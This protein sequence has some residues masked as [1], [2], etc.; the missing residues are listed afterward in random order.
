MRWARER[1]GASVHVNTYELDLS[2]LNVYHF[3]RDETWFD[4]ILDNRAGRP[5]VLQEADVVVGPVAND[6]IYDT[7]GVIES[8]LLDRELAF[9]LLAIGSVYEQT[10]I[11]SGKASAQLKWLSCTMP[12]SAEIAKY[13]KTVAEEEA[14]FQKAVYEMLESL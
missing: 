1:G 12:G 2:S 11:K 14:E 9:R 4:Y 8:G 13:R 7:V 5:D 10:V 6:T 3:N